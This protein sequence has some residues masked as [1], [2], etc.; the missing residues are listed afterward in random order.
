ME[1]RTLKEYTTEQLQVAIESLK[2][3]GLL[4]DQEVILMD[5]LSIEVA[6][7]LGQPKGELHISVI[8]GGKSLSK[9]FTP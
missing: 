2:L 3:I 9:D 7:R 5:N 4:T 1:Q 6:E 8:E